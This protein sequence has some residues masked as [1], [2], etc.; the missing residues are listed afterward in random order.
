MAKSSHLKSRIPLIG[1]IIFFVILFTIPLTVFLSN[2]STS[3]V[4]EAARVRY[5]ILLL[6]QDPKFSGSANFLVTGGDVASGELW[7]LSNCYQNSVLVYQ[8]YRKVASDGNSA[9]FTLGPTPSWT[10]GGADCTAT[11]GMFRRGSSWRALGSMSFTV[12]P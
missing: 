11:L 2:N 12:L 5:Q 9:T 3:S 8:Q 10:S 7:I 4:S 1:V 6:T